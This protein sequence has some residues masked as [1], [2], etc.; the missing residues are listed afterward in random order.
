MESYT[1]A[2][3][4]EQLQAVRGETRVKVKEESV[5]NLY[6]QMALNEVFEEH[7]W[8]FTRVPGAPVTFDVNGRLILPDDFSMF[9]DWCIHY[10]TSTC[11]KEQQDEYGITIIASQ[12]DGKLYMIGADA[13]TTSISYH[14]KAPNLMDDNTSKVFLPS[15]LPMKVAERAYVR[16]K[17][18][19]FPD[20]TSE[21][22]LAMSRRSLRET[23]TSSVPRQKFTPKKR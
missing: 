7:D 6:L 18:A 3:L 12:T 2:Q 15:S 8:P 1:M 13:G 20:E 19:Y 10:G 11:S 16:L 14:S 22:E 4:R 23:Y 17:T 9:N 21:K 5:R